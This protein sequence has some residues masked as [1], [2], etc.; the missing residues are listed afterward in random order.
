VL[1]L[2]QPRLVH[3][4]EVVIPGDE[5][6][7][8]PQVAGMALGATPMAGRPLPVKFRLVDPADGKARS[9]VKDVRVVSFRVPGDDRSQS[10]ARPGADGFY[11]TEIAVP[12]SGTY[13]LFVEAPSVA[14]V[15]TAGRLIQVPRQDA[16]ADLSRGKP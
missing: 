7:P 3:C 2:D 5:A 4:F 11:E 13:Y 6:N 14:L 8:P 10:I 15:P 9:G 1:Y 16:A 12:D